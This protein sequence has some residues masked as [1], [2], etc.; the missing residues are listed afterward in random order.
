MTF[1]DF[2][3]GGG[4]AMLPVTAFGLAALVAGARYAWRPEDRLIAVLRALSAATAFAGIAAL[5]ADLAAVMHKVPANPEWAKSPDLP[6]IVMMGIGESLAP[7][8][9]GFGL[10]GLAWVLAAAGLRRAEP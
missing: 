5:C 9:V 3:L 1:S 10:L 2:F 6:L 7:P 8:I 4:G